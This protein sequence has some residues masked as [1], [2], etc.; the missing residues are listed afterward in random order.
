[1]LIITNIH[2]DYM[3]QPLGATA[4]PQFGWAIESSRSQVVQKAYQLQI[5]KD[6]NF[7]QIVYDSLWVECQESA[8][9]RVNSY[10]LASATKYFV[11]VRI[12]DNYLE[13]SEWSNIAYFVTGL[14]N[15]EWIAQ[16]ITGET[17]EDS[18]NSKGTYIKQSFFITKAIKEAYSF[19]SALGL[20]HAYL[21]G[22]PVSEDEMAPGWTTYKKRLMY[23]TNEVTHLIKEGEN[24]LAAHLGAGWYKGLIGLTK[25]RNLYGDRTAFIGQI[26]VTYTDGTQEV[27]GTND[28][29]LSTDSPVI[30]SEIYDGETYDATKEIPEWNTS[31]SDNS[32]WKKVNK[33]EYPLKQLV[34]QPGSRVKIMEYVKPIE[35]IKTPKNETVIDFGQN[36]A[37][38]IRFSVDGKLGEKVQL[39]CFEVLDSE[40]NVY[41]DNLRAAKQTLTYT[42]SGKGIISYQPFFTY[43]GFR[44]AKVCHYPGE[45]K[46][47]NFIACS[48]YSD[49]ERTGYF[50]CSNQ[51]LNQLQHNILWGLKS[52]FLDVPTDCPQRDER[53]GWTGD[54]QIF[55]RTASYLVNT[56]QFFSKWLKDLAADQTPEGGVTHVVPDIIT[57]ISDDNWLLK[58]GTHSAAAWAD[59]AVINPW[60]LYLTFGDRGIIQEQYTSMKAWIDFM[61]THSVDGI[62]NYKLQFGDWVALDAEEGSY[63]GATPNDLTCTAY[64]A[65]STGLFA[66]MA[67][68]IGHEDDHV[69][70]S[71]LYDSIVKGFV[72]HFFDQDGNL[73][74][75]TQTAHIIA[76]YFDLT[77]QR[78]IQK[79][80]NQLVALIHKENG[81]L[82]TGFVGTPYICHALSKHGRIEEAY[83]LLLKDDLPSWLYQVKMGA[84]TIWEHWDGLKPDGT[85][86]SPGMNSFN[87][88]AYGAI[89][90]WLYR[91]IIGLEI[92]EE[93]PGYK[94]VLIHPIFGGDLDYADGTYKSIYGDVTSRWERHDELYRLRVTIP[95]NTTAKIILE[96][97]AYLKDN[98]GLIFQ[99]TQE[100]FVT[101]V[102]SGTYSLLFALKE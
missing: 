35:V 70:Y 99:Q 77:P 61:T 14:V 32:I 46:L 45:V 82:V 52:N 98:A 91:V 20:Y 4:H 88:Y 58:Q 85:M 57:G 68:Y 71:K 75:M 72:Q 43:Q 97:A 37:G 90:E 69:V 93:N 65:Y 94:H 27:F 48:V 92:D 25:K 44:Y 73:T 6:L 87:H 17:I 101:E 13:K 64:Y 95:P 15:Q 36:M 31:L 53:L 12:E 76:L 29:G 41:I 86:W 3:K 63:F 66:K 56:H 60:T 62:W 7:H 5:A 9:I 102:G 81:H 74:A 40:G 11:R 42:C 26:H 2:I 23:Q 59:A 51:E 1:M 80:V 24:Y 10:E 54:A 89:G 18:Q 38:W 28:S 39:H 21:N 79:T 22:E 55:C 30:F 83:A 50:E 67:K 19:T 78:Y 47:E 8:H 16:F 96:Q 34:S 33:V 100:G 84:T 49:M